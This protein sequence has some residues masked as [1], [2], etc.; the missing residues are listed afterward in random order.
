MASVG[1][2]NALLLTNYQVRLAIYFTQNQQNMDFLERLHIIHSYMGL[3]HTL[4]AVLAMISG[5]MVLL[6]AK[7]DLQHRRTGR[8]YSM[9]MLLMIVSSFSIYNFGGFS[10]FHGFSIISFV[11]LVL[12]LYP[13]I[14]RNG[15]WFGKHFYFM[16]WSVVGLYCAFWAE[17]GVRFFDMRYFWW[18]VMVATMATAFAG[19]ILI[20]KAAKKHK[21]A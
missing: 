16:N 11:T 10:L 7:G 19:M 13:A 20:N 3:F 18:V 21:L 4:M 12:G 6:R 8:V 17:V 15:N 14:R 5:S 2:I 9:S 1:F